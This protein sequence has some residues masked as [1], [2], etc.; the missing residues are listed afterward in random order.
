MA[1]LAKHA[2]RRFLRGR[3]RS[4]VYSTFLEVYM[5]ST[6]LVS[7]ALTLMF[8]P[9][10]AFGCSCAPPPPGTKSVRELGEW[11]SQGIAAIFEGNVEDDDLKS[12]L[13]EASVGYL[14]PP[15]L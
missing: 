4:P 3:R 15:H 11:K 13:I 7:I 1:W 8:N 12:R 5:R 10:S 2:D 6:V 9:A 14:I